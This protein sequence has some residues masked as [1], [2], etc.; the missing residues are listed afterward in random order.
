MTM[1]RIAVAA[2][3]VAALAAAATVATAS[4]HGEGRHEDREA[5]DREHG[6]HGSRPRTGSARADTATLALYRK[7]CGACHLAF[8]PGYLG[9]ASHRRVLAG[10]E[11]HF[12]QNAELDPAVRDRL[13]AW[14]VANAAEGGSHRGS[15]QVLDSTAPGDAPLR[16]TEAS[17]FQRKHRKVDARVL[18]RPSVKTLANCAACH[19]G[20]SDWDFDDDRVKIPAS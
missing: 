7:E 2:W 9:A 16:L 5:E 13:E 11:R 18:A 4:D 20:A 17:W 8:P 12:G 3:A 15:R 14:L 10:L 19:A 1:K 6:E